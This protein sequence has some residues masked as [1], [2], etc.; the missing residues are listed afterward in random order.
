MVEWLK[1]H[2]YDQY[3]LCSKFTSTIWQCSKK[4]HFTELFPVCQSWHTVLSFN[5]ISKAIKL[6]K[7]K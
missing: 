6:K 5:Y 2:N 7:P 4:K 1:C 3:G